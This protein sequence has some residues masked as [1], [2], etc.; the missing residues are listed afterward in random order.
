[1]AYVR[2][3]EQGAKETV[4]VGGRAMV[5]VWDD[6]DR[7]LLGDDGSVICERPSAERPVLSGAGGKLAAAS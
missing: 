1:V 5:A 4:Q 6:Q 2:L 3:S 7:D